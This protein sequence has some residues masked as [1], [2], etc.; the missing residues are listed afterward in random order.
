MD[1]PISQRCTGDVTCERARDHISRGSRGR[2]KQPAR[3]DLFPVPRR[4]CRAATHRRLI[5]WR[6]MRS[7]LVSALVSARH[8]VAFVRLGRPLFS[9]GG[10][11]LYGLGA[12]AAACSTG[13]PIAWGRFALGQLAITAAQLMTH[14]CNDY[15]DLE[16]D[17][18]NLT[19]TRW[20]G[21]SRILP[22]GELPAI[23]A[24]AAALAL[25]LVA[26]IA[27]ARLAAAP[28]SGPLTFPLYLGI[29]VL[30]WEYSAPPL[31]LHSTGW[32][33]LDAALVVAC[34]T[35]VAG[36]YFQTGRM[37][38]LPFLAA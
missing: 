8:L 24:L 37:A 15:F 10:F 26:L 18:A 31:R 2:A 29:V 23:T 12:A 25:G 28:G 34:L 20:S 6:S 21:G 16:A 1:S 5:F 36:Y 22:A 32:G 19:P 3:I 11:A 35:P 9:V 4:H 38:A 33:E 13:Q 17:R 14:Y 27:G 30:A 7:V